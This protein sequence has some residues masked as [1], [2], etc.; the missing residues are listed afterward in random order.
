MAV[1]P[2]QIFID[3]SDRIAKQYDVLK[4]TQEYCTSGTD[5]Y[6]RIHG[7]LPT[8]GDYQVEADLIT[9]ANT[10][11]TKM[12]DMTTISVPLFTDIIGA[13]NSH[14]QSRGGAQISSLGDYLTVS[15]IRVHERFAEAYEDV[16]GSALKA[17]YVF[18]ADEVQMGFVTFSS[19]G[20][21]VFTDGTQLNAGTGQ[22]YVRRSITSD[23]L[24][25][26][27]I[28]SGSSSSN[29]RVVNVIGINNEG[30]TV[31]ASVTIDN[32]FHSGMSAQ[33]NGAIRF[34]DVT[35]IQVAGGNAGDVI[36]IRSI[37]D[38]NVGL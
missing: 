37:V 8:D 24:V 13:L 16:T 28:A 20:V 4:A 1:I 27:R 33:I 38:R 3:I 36:T 7:D 25:Q 19:S 15:G 2:K 6:V 11:D 5:F 14:V 26:Y 12:A 23:A 9:P 31:S 34:A 29:D 10:A 18:R 32:S 35:T 30:N 17:K 21:A 22:D